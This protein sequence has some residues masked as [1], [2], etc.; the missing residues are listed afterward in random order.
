MLSVLGHLVDIYV[1]TIS[2]GEV[3]CLDNAVVV[4]ANL[5]NQT[6]VQEALKVYQGGMEEVRHILIE[7]SCFLYGHV[8]KFY[9]TLYISVCLY[10]D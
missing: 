3:P 9:P 2:S 5:E 6:A 1:D 7:F 4:L 8:S 10:T